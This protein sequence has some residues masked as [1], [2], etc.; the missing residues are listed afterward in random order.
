M[1]AIHDEQPEIGRGH[2]RRGS[3]L[4]I[5]QAHLAEEVPR[6]QLATGSNRRSH[7]RHA[8]DDDEERLARVS[9]LRDDSSHRSLDDPRELG[10]STKL[11]LVEP[12]E[13]RNS[14][15]MPS[16]RIA[17]GLDGAGLHRLCLVLEGQA[18]SGSWI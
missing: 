5:E 2:D 12:A 3:G 18:I 14:L 9:Y 4:P 13:E 10:D 1:G 11:V 16:L 6:L 15:Q 7:R 17:G 8:V